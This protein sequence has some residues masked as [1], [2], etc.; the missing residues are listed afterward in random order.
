MRTIRIIATIV[1]A[2][3]AG[4]ASLEGAPFDPR[5]NK[6]N[7]ARLVAGKSTTAQVREIFG[8][9]KR[10]VRMERQ[11]RDVWEYTYRYY[12]EYRVLWVQFSGDGLVREVLDMLDWSAYPPSGPSMP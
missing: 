11:Q 5:V 7:I 12:D 10:A 3:L 4:C 1:L 2:G 8:P 9:P 6:D